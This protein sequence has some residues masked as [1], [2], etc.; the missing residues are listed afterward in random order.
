MTTSS[1]VQDAWF[2]SV[3]NTSTVKE[4][5]TIFFAH[6]V[7]FNSEFETARLRDA[8]SKINY[9]LYTTTRS[10]TFQI[11]SL[12]TQKFE[13]RLEYTREIRVSEEAEDF[14]QFQEALEVIEDQAVTQLGKTWGGLVDYW[15]TSE[16]QPVREQISVDGKQCLRAALIYTGFKHVALA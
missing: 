6:T 13:V 16:G 4:Y 5:C 9:I 11:G 10:Q 2:D 1:Q 14:E 8:E 15:R 12:A 3:L 7:A